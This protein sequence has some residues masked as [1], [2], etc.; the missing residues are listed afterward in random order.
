[1]FVAK[2]RPLTRFCVKMH[3]YQWRMK[4]QNVHLNNSN[5]IFKITPI[6]HTLNWNKLFLKYCDASREIVGNTLSQLEK[7]WHDHPIHFVSKQFILV[8]TKY[9]EQ[10]GGS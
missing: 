3:L 8:K 6:L 9:Y 4:R 10:I 2:T 7:N 1:M 5:Q